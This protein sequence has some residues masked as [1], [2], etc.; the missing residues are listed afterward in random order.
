MYGIIEEDAPT[1]DMVDFVSEGMIFNEAWDWMGLGALVN[2]PVY[3]DDAGEVQIV[4]HIGGQMP[5]GV[6]TGAQEI[7]FS[8]RLFSQVEASINFDISMSYLGSPASG[9]FI[10]HQAITRDTEIIDSASTDHSGFAD[11]APIGGTAVFELYT[12]TDGG[13]K[14][15]HGTF[16]FAEGSKVITSQNIDTFNMEAGDVMHLQCVTDYSIGAITLTLKGN[17]IV[18]WRA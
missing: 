3:I 13:S 12:S 4:P 8:P 18:F 16:E 10:A 9:E 11:N 17:T 2:D 14:V 5:I 1:G 15:P 7:M 6:V